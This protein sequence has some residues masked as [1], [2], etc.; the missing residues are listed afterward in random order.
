MNMKRKLFTLTEMLIVIAVIAIL[1]GILIPTLIYAR[2]R[3]K[4]AD[5]ASN[6]GQ[7]GKLFISALDKNNNKIV[8]GTSGNKL[9]SKALLDAGLLPSLEVAR[10]TAMEYTGDDEYSEAFGVVVAGNADNTFDFKSNKLFR[11]DARVEV[12]RASLLMGGCTTDDDGKPQATLDFSDNKLALVHSGEVN[13]F[14]IDGSVQTLTADGFKA[15]S[16]Y[17]PATGNA[18]AVSNNALRDE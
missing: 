16:F 8:S 15:G 17:Y 6:Q 2:N 13:I 10:C 7:I 14:F 3:A 11:T 9:W 18:A 4:L 5:C 1:A 12:P